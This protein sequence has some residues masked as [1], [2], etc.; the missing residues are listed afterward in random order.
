MMIK[1]SQD[2]VEFG[3]STFRD[4]AV[5]G[6]V[7]GMWMTACTLLVLV[8]VGCAHWREEPGQPLNHQICL[9]CLGM[10][11]EQGAV[12]SR[13]KTCGLLRRLSDDFFGMV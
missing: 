3:E 8:K 13:T 2:S 5:G 1:L 9:T 4:Y 10:I 12:P 7:L 6:R 11:A